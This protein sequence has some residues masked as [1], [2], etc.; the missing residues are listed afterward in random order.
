MIFSN[1][2]KKRDLSGNLDLERN[3]VESPISN[4][5]YIEFTPKRRWWQ[6][7]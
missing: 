6:W 5:I 3:K 1:K 4:N 7:L 2:H